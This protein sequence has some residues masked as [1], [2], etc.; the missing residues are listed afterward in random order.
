[1][2]VLPLVRI[3]RDVH[4]IGQTP[5]CCVRRQRMTS[6]EGRS[7]PC[8]TISNFMDK[9]IKDIKWLFSELWKER[10][11]WLLFA[12]LTVLLVLGTGLWNAQSP[13]GSSSYL[14]SSVLL[15]LFISLLAAALI[16]V[17]AQLRKLI[18][19]RKTQK[20]FRDL[21]GFTGTGASVAVVLPKFEAMIKDDWTERIKDWLN[22]KAV[23]PIKGPYPSIDASVKPDLVAASNLVAAFSEASFQ[24]PTIIWD[25]EAVREI[26]DK[27]SLYTTFIAVGLYSNA[28]TVWLNQK[29]NIERLFKLEA[30]WQE[31]QEITVTN[32][33]FNLK[34]ANYEEKRL[35]RNEDTWESFKYEDK[36][37]D[38]ALV[39]K[40]RLPNDKVAVVFGGMEAVATERLG[41]FLR[42][43]WLDLINW[44]DSVTQKK[45]GSQ[46]F[47]TVVEVPLVGNKEVIS[48]QKVRVSN[49]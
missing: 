47:A 28:L 5:E 40:V 34:L 10:R 30:Y 18:D 31:G 24:I 3:Q 4:V 49:Y 27:N 42:E 25:D 21:F 38:Y 6:R 2:L 29:Y 35:N 37:F 36:E 48:S 17:L 39:A 43:N 19:V 7:K 16:E 45:I 8:S 32:V 44:R 11:G 15:N 41:K 13:L 20:M 9:I 46:Q 23:T 26:D 14:W 33:G 22:N 12:L 1:M